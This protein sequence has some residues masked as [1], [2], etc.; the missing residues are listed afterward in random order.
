[1]RLSL[2][3]PLPTACTLLLE[4]TSLVMALSPFFGVISPMVSWICG[5]LYW[6]LLLEHDE[7]HCPERRFVEHRVD[8]P[9]FHCLTYAAEVSSHVD[10]SVHE[11]ADYYSR[12]LIN[13]SRFSIP[14]SS[15]TFGPKKVPWW[16]AQCAA[17]NAQRKR[18]LRKYKRS[19]LVADKVAYCRARA[20]AKRVKLEARQSSWRDYVIP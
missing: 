18:T 9:S 17:A 1:M 5:P 11:F 3:L 6:Q 4:L 2:V 7:D 13:A 20:V 19:L 15:G 16:N 14:L 10:L 8:W 12:H